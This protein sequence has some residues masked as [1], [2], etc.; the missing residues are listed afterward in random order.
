MLSLSCKDMGMTDD[1][2]ETG[3]TADEVMKKAMA[4]AKVAH[5]DKLKGTPAQLADMEKLM[6]SKIK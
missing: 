6:R 2:V 3:N 4:H 1:H 5:A